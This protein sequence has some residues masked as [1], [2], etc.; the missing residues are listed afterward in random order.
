MPKPKATRSRSTKRGSQSSRLLASSS[1]LLQK[2]MLVALLLAAVTVT[3]L[4]VRQAGHAAGATVVK[5]G[6]IA[7]SFKNSSGQVMCLD[8]YQGGT[9]N[10]SAINIFAC[11][12]NDSSQVWSQYS[13]GTL[14]IKSKCLDVYQNGTADGSRIELFTCNGAANQRW[15]RGT[16]VHVSLNNLVGAQSGKCLDDANYGTTNN[17]K[18]QL[19]TCNG[20]TAQVWGWVT[21]AD[22]LVPGGETAYANC[23]SVISGGNTCFYWSRAHQ[24]NDGNYSASG[25]SASFT[26]ADPIIGK[27][28]PGDGGTLHHSVAQIWASAPDT[29]QI[30]EIGWYKDSTR[31]TSI[32]F[33]TRWINGQSK[34]IQNGGT[35]FV[36]VSSSVHFGDKVAIGALGN[37]KIQLVGSQWQLWYN[38]VEVGYFP[39]SLWSNQGASFNTIANVHVYG[40]VSSG[41]YTV[42]KTQMGNG[43]L[44]SR[45]GSTDFKNYVL[46]NSSEPAQLV[47]FAGPQAP[48]DSAYDF[49]NPTA[50][51]FTFGGPGF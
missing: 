45:S 43:I 12:R 3:G 4:V 36:Q 37:Y 23:H 8:D 21:S 31:S 2:P 41:P 14:R 39:Q 11:N 9:A 10:G 28:W 22:P 42:T 17:N 27:Q 6:L 19:W 25:V 32:L 51:G 18:T 48:A 44:G 5:T 24:Q 29:N 50:T 46:I 16:N 13:D 34:Y 26:Q 7:T 20:G 30:I 40:E 49:G 33:G 15:T 1:R 47:D 38:G 35:G